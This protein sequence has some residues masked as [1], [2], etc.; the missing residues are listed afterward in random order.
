MHYPNIFL[1]RPRKTTEIFKI[2]VSQRRFELDT[3]KLQIKALHLRQPVRTVT[4]LYIRNVLNVKG[5]F[6]SQL[7]FLCRE[8]LC[9]NSL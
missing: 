9:I 3:S 6:Y 4:S 8:A 1:E 7:I 5:P 2:N